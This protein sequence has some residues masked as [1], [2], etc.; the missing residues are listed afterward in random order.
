MSSDYV[1]IRLDYQAAQRCFSQGL[2]I[3]SKPSPKDKI[4]LAVSLKALFC[5]RIRRC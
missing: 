2:R 4:F 3:V 1:Q 5:L